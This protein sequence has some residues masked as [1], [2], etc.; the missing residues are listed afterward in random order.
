MGRTCGPLILISGVYPGVED[1]TAGVYISNGTG[2]HS[3]GNIYPGVQDNT[4]GGIHI[5]GYKMTHQGVN[6][7]RGT[8]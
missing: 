8:G 2:R 4:T 3:R 1:D 6:V 5:Q 7:P